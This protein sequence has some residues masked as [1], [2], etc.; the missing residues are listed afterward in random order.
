[1]IDIGPRYGV[2]AYFRDLREKTRS[3]AGPVSTAWFED[4][5]A[6][7]RRTMTPATISGMIADH[8]RIVVEHGGFGFIEK[9]STVLGRP[10]CHSTGYVPVAVRIRNHS[11]D[12]Q[13]YDEDVVLVRRL[14][15]E[16]SS[17]RI[18]YSMATAHMAITR[19][20]LERLYVRAGCHY[21]TFAETLRDEMLRSMCGLA[22]AAAADIGHVRS[23]RPAD[24]QHQ[25]IPFGSGLMIM[26]GRLFSDW[27][28]D[29]GHRVPL[30]QQSVIKN[31]RSQQRR[32]LLS[33]FNSMIVEHPEQ[34]EHRVWA[35]RVFTTRTYVDRVDMTRQKSSYHE[36][37]QRLLDDYDFQP[38]LQTYFRPRPYEDD[39]PIEIDLPERA[40]ELI[41][42][43]TREASGMFDVDRDIPVCSVREQ[44][45]DIVTTSDGDDMLRP[46]KGR[47]GPVGMNVIEIVEAVHR[48]SGADAYA[49]GHAVLRHDD[50]GTRDVSFMV[51][52]G[53][54]AALAS[55]LVV[56]AVL[57]VP[58]RWTAPHAITI[59]DGRTLAAAGTTMRDRGGRLAA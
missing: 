1:M 3:L 7:T 32:P 24:Y 40:L 58:V 31:G 36:T 17:R 18:V 56:G 46:G 45:G 29:G 37:F 21:T 33:R 39:S 12:G 41:A 8:E 19:H 44:V 30:A 13:P 53:N 38:L 43:L 14:D 51:Q 2:R 49:R 42:E 35:S 15:M 52:G 34:T 28:V 26:D 25:A 59:V 20:A 50:G 27:N 11:A 9:W 47:P 48:G 23:S 57:E 4:A 16:V 54:Y 55:R 10:A 6:A 5:C 22:I